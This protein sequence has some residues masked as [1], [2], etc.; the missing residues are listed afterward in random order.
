MY[1]VGGHDL[2]LSYIYV[3]AQTVSWQLFKISFDAPFTKL[4]AMTS[5]FTPLTRLLKLSVSIPQEHALGPI[6][7]PV[8]PVLTSPSHPLTPAASPVRRRTSLPSPD[9]EPP[10][11][12]FCTDDTKLS[13]SADPSLP[14]TREVKRFVKKCPRLVELGKCAFARFPSCCIDGLLQS[15]MDV[16]HVEGG[17]FRGL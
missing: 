17:S 15:G 8:S 4:L 1:S 9:T 10:S 6:P 7:I 11:Q 2:H 14:P 5:A 12:F 13:G 3:S 16:T